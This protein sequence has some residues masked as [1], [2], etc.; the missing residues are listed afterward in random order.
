MECMELNLLMKVHERPYHRKVQV[1]GTLG[2]PVPSW[3][4][5][6]DTIP[7]AYPPTLSFSSVPS[8]LIALFSRILNLPILNDSRK[9]I[10]ALF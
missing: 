2:Q 8:L 3:G 6:L 1:G 4:L 5:E 9:L 10:C 7:G